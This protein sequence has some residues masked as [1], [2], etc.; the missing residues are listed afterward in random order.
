MVAGV[1]LQ[2]SDISVAPVVSEAMLFPL[3]YW[4]YQDNVK[5]SETEEQ[6]RLEANSHQGPTC[7]ASAARIIAGSINGIPTI[8]LQSSVDIL[9]L[10]RPN[11]G[12]CVEPRVYV[13]LVMMS[14]L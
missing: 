7:R 13:V 10:P 14:S 6:R 5:A 1:V 2:R 12:C 8:A 3:G 11:R 9:E 4:R